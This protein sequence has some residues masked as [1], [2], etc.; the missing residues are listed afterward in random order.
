MPDLE[1]LAAH[2]IDR[3][4]LA[5]EAKAA[6]KAIQ[7][8]LAAQYQQSFVAMVNAIERQASALERLQTTLNLLIAKIEPDLAGQLP[9]PIRVVN[10]GEAPDVASAVVLA[11]PIAAGYTLT[12]TRI[13][14]ALGIS[15]GDVSVLVRAFGIVQDGECAVTVRKGKKLDVV[16]YHPRAI[17]RLRDAIASPPAKLTADQ[18][19]A[20]ARARRALRARNG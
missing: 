4:D 18:R 16:N 9:V 19:N 12:Q 8:E 20:L 11:D 3:L 17:D 2:A 7:A 5:P 1:P 14:D 15:S 13:A 6:L 10:H